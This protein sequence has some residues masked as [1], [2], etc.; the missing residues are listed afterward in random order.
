MRRDIVKYK[1]LSRSALLLSLAVLFWAAQILPALA[2]PGFCQ[3][4]SAVGHQGCPSPANHHG[5][6]CCC[7]HAD[8]HSG[9]KG[10]CCDVREAERSAHPDLAVSLVPNP[11][12]PDPIGLVA[13]SRC[14]K[15]L[16]PFM[17]TT[18]AFDWVQSK[19]LS[20]PIYLN[21]LNFLC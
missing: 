2:G 11:T 16:D 20:K 12:N 9:L 14:S 10:Q 3:M 5:H 7:G 13:E 18:G 4:T 8:S 19:S 21:N 15:D 17:G 1:R 6:G